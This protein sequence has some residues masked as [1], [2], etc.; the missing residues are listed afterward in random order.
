M[1]RR[2]SLFN[3]GIGKEKG[4]YLGLDGDAEKLATEGVEGDNIW[5]T[6]HLNRE[7]W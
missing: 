7:I 3:S 5:G 6:L 2:F 4:W 1:I